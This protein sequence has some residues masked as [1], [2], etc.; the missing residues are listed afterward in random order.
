M[1][2]DTRKSWKVGRLEGWTGYEEATEETFQPSNLPTFQEGI[3][4]WL[5]QYATVALLVVGGLEWLLGRTLSRLGSAPPLQGP[6]RDAI[7]ALGR[8]GYFLVSPSFILAAFLLLL[9]AFLLGTAALRLDS[10]SKVQSPKSKPS[11]SPGLW[12]LDF[13]LAVYLALFAVL[14]IAHTFAAGQENQQWLNMLLNIASLLAIWWVC[15]RFLAARDGPGAAKVGMLL[16][17]IG[18]SGSF[19]YVLQQML[20]ASDGLGGAGVAARDVGELVAVAAPV[21]FFVAVAGRTGEWRRA[22]RWLAPLF[23]ALLFAAGSIADAAFNQGFTAIFTNWSLGFNLSWPWPL[24]AVA[25]AL[26]AYSVL[27]C[28]SGEASPEK[29]RQPRSSYANPNTGVGLLVLLLA[30]LF[31]QLPYQHLLACLSLLLLAG[32][33]KPMGELK[34]TDQPS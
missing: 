33:F 29:G 28:F 20:A 9:A 26:Y 34:T 3:D 21:G 8:V 1:T 4:H 2:Q 18:Y 27:T 15:A 13:G 23:L 6:A 25:L 19:W 12:T 14:A 24:Y 31:L 5:A 22:R 16:V 10:R 7:E 32:L 30:G 17:V 11:G